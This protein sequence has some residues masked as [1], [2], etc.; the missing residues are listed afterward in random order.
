MAIKKSAPKKGTT[1][2]SAAKKGKGTKPGKQKRAV[3]KAAPPKTASAPSPSCK[4]LK[5]LSKFYCYHLING[6]WE[7][8]L[9][10]GFPSREMCEEN[11]CG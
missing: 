6:G 2:K 9:A 4:C 7:R 8:A 5:R 11:C 1:K 10:T 3:S